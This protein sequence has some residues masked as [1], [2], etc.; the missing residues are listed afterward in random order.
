MTVRN[1]TQDSDYH[2]DAVPWLPKLGH[3]CRNK[4]TLSSLIKTGVNQ[5]SIL[6]LFLFSLCI[7][8]IMNNAA[9]DERGIRQTFSNMLSDLDYADDIFLL[10]YHHNDMQALTVE[11]ASTASMLG[12]RWVGGCAMMP[13]TSRGFHTCSHLGSLVSSNQLLNNEDE[14]ASDTVIVF[15]KKSMQWPWSGLEPGLLGSKSSMP[16][17]GHCSSHLINNPKIENY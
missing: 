11:L 3:F 15:T 9:K 5:G 10:A 4:L 16:T 14:I 1:T 2:Q 17:L 12:L 6:S 7:G 8:W 13:V